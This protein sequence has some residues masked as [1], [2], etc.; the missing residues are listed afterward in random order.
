MKISF[1]FLF[2]IQTGF[3]VFIRPFKI[4]HFRDVATLT[5][6]FYVTLVSWP[7]L[8]ASILQENGDTV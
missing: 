5:G 3:G 7:G 2:E 6:I 4:S 1:L 8:L